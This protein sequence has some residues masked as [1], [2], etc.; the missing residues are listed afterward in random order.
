M[1]TLDRLAKSSAAKA[2]V[3]LALG[4]QD[5]MKKDGHEAPAPPSSAK[6]MSG[7]VFIS[8]GWFRLS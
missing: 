7:F 8:M 6:H 3:S 4:S 1:R 5:D 2:L